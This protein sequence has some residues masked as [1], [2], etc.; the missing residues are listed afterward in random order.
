MCQPLPPHQVLGT[1][2]Q[3][4]LELLLHLGLERVTVAQA[5]PEGAE[6]G[7]DAGRCEGWRKR[8]DQTSSLGL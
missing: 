5:A 1:Q 3:M 8:H 7:G 4:V 2:R 6:S